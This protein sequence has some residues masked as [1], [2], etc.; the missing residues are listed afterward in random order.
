MESPLSLMLRN[1]LE[2]LPS[3]VNHF[4]EG[5][6]PRIIVGIAGGITN[7][8]IGTVG[9]YLQLIIWASSP[10]TS[11]LKS[12]ESQ[13]AFHKEAHTSSVMFFLV[14]YAKRPRSVSHTY[15]SRLQSQLSCYEA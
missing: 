5:L 2:G 8:L 10:P 15:F 3:K 4:F 1:P 14:S 6:E 7:F 12:K 11:S 9:T 13:G